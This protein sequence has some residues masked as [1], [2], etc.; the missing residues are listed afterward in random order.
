[1]IKKKN[2]KYL[3]VFVLEVS[4]SL[5]N[6]PELDIESILRKKHSGSGAGFGQRDISFYYNRSSV[7][8]KAYLKL[9]KLKNLERVSISKVY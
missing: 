5:R 3:P 6:Y 8:I 9:C 1:M 7:A 2:R 4:Y